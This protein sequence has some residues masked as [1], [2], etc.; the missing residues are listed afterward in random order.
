V[1][2]SDM[3]GV[4]GVVRWEQVIAGRPMYE[5]GRRLYTEDVNAAIRGAFT[6][7]ATDVVVMDWHG[8]GGGYSFNSLIPDGLDSR[9]RYVVQERVPQYTRILEDGCDAALLVGMH[10]RARTVD[11]VMNHTVFGSSWQ[12]LW[13]NG[14][15]VGEPGINAALC[16]TWGCPVVLVTGDEA[17]CE[18]TRE[19]LGEAV[20]AVPVKRGIGRTSAVLVPPVRARQMIEAG[21]AEALSRVGSARPYDPGRPCEI[22]VEFQ[23]TAAWEEF[24]HRH[25]VE[26][27]GERRI[28]CTGPDWWT[29]WSSFMQV[30]VYTGSV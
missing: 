25:G 17:T 28:R 13:F 23:H 22:V 9:C 3:E 5:E 27:A 2:I 19:L 11:G 21:A 24:R 6:G 4:S 14:T 18:Q 20:A 12:N 30:A 10:A 15:L 8:A 1:I 29:A 16:G 26:D 7:G